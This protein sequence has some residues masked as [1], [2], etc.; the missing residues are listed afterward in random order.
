[1][2]GNHCVHHMAALLLVSVYSESMVVFPRW[3]Q[4]NV[5]DIIMCP[6]IGEL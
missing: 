6:A 1:M 3:T 5:K 2:R 4:R